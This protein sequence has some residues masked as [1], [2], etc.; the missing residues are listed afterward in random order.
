M[1]YRLRLQKYKLLLGRDF[2][3]DIFCI[4]N[5]MRHALFFGKESLHHCLHSF[6]FCFVETEFLYEAV[7]AVQELT[8]TC[9]PLLPPERWD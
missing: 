8:E 4:E 3:L 6:S 7:L 2:P 9:L 1:K 5:E